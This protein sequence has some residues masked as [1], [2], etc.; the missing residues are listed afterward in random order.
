MPCGTFLFHQR[1]PFQQGFIVFS[2][3]HHFRKL[4]VYSK[5]SAHTM[6]DFVE[7]LERFRHPAT[8]LLCGSR[9][10]DVDGGKMRRSASSRKAQ[11]PCSCSLEFFIDDFIHQLP[12]STS[13]VAM[14]VRLP[15]S[16]IFRARH[17]RA[18][19]AAG[20][21]PPTQSAAAWR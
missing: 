20:S 12:V 4:S 21:I 3:F 9:F 7:V 1:N 15:P 19:K 16:S 11:V 14:I 18:V 13:A 2:R 6:A 10:F 5:A 17:V 8:G